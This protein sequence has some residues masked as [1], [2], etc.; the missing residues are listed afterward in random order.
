VVGFF[1]GRAFCFEFQK[2]PYTR[3]KAAKS[4]CIEEI[5]IAELPREAR[6]RSTMVKEIV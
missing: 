5:V 1:S 6:Q 3:N 4:V 2:S